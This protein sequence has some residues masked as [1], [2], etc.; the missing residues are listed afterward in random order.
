MHFTGGEVAK[1]RRFL[2]DLGIESMALNLSAYFSQRQPAKLRD[3]YAG[4]PMILYSSE[5]GLDQNRVDEFIGHNGD[6]FTMIYGLRTDHPNYVMEWGGGDINDFYRIAEKSTRIGVSEGVALDPAVMRYISSFT[7]KNNL[8]LVTAS[9]KAKVLIHHWDEVILGAWISASK[10]R[11][12]QVWDGRHVARYSRASRAA[13]IDKH[14]GQIIALGGDPD[15]LAD[16]VTEE[17]LKVAVRSWIIYGVRGAS[18]V[19]MDDHRQSSE[20]DDSSYG[21]VATAPTATRTRER[22]SLPVLA[23]V[24]TPAQAAD[25]ADTVSL[26]VNQRALRTCSSC[27]LSQACP[28]FEPGM[29]CAFEIPMRIT[30]KHELKAAQSALLEIQ[31][32]RVLFGRYAE[33]VLSQGLDPALSSELERFMRMTE[34]VKRSE[35]RIEQMTITA[36]TESGVISRLF[37]EEAGAANTKLAN[38]IT[39]NELSEIVYDGELVDEPDTDR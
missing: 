16:D 34:S 22:I 20:G 10:Q 30:N 28:S 39:A 19:A 21:G 35:Q 14:H 31:F 37:G 8:G 32:H 13:A 2:L 12:L 9:S 11:E 18:V 15:A 33:E 4:F 27:N 29:P 7:R 17:L 36:T 3:S 5:G 38:S 26:G 25:G 23:S 24:V 6:A 1:H